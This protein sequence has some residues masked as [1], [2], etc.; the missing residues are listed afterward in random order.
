MIDCTGVYYHSEMGKMCGELENMNT[1]VMIVIEEKVKQIIWSEIMA[2]SRHS[3]CMI[4][5][6]VS[7]SFCFSRCACILLMLAMNG[8]NCFFSIFS[9]SR[10]NRTFSEWASRLSHLEEGLVSSLGSTLAW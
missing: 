4:S 2:I 10:M 5:R 6:L 8:W 9:I 7:S 3:F 1:H